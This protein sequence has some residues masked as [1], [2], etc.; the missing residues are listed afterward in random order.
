MENPID[1]F[2]RFREFWVS[3]CATIDTAQDALSIEPW[4]FSARPDNPISEEPSNHLIENELTQHRN[5]SRERNDLWIYLRVGQTGTP[6]KP[7]V[8]FTTPNYPA[9][10]IIYDSD[11]GHDRKIRSLILS[12]LRWIQE[13]LN[14]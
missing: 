4:Q 1:E 2:V 11:G 7:I 6:P 10:T 3:I 12:E 14:E 8:I 13:R 9:E 5:Y